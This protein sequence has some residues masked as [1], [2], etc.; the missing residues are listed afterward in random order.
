MDRTPP[1][2][3]PPGPRELWVDVMALAGGDG[4]AQHPAKDLSAVLAPNQ[5]VHLKSGLYR[6]PFTLPKDVQLI[7]EGQAVLYVE[8][9]EGAVVSMPEGGALTRLSVQGGRTGVVG[10]KTV[11][12]EQVH[13]SGHRFAAL[14]MG[15]GVLSANNVEVEASVPDSAGFV[16]DATP[17]TPAPEE[18]GTEPPG[19]RR[20][21]DGVKAALS[22]TLRG[23]DFRGGLKHA[24][25][26]RGA[27]LELSD[28]ELDGVATPIRVR[29]S[30]AVLRSVSLKAG[31][32]PAVFAAD[33]KVSVNGLEVLGHEYAFQARASELAVEGVH[34]VGSEHASVAA[35]QCTGSLKKLRLERPGN[36]AAIQVLSSKL[37]IGEV[38]IRDAD[39]AGIMVRQGEVA[40]DG[41]KV[42]G[43]RA[44]ANAAGT[45]DTG[46]DALMLRGCTGTVKRVEIED[47]E[48]VG[49][50]FSAAAAMQV[51]GLSCR[52]CGLGAMLVELASRIQASRV[53]VDGAHGPAVSVI[54][55]GQ[56]ELA[57]LSSHGAEVPVWAECGNGA[58]AK[59]SG[60]EGQAQPSSPCVLVKK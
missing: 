58:I 20:A 48:G 37:T 19:P 40:I 2:V 45:R 60:V 17:E 39:A 13:F 27:S 55:H 44:E 8:G 28:S 50:W 54:D 30:V 5:R 43:V 21:L 31:R 49:A 59:V 53:T 25:D 26:V 6:G 52:R 29:D 18:N 4:S 12:L 47:A 14:A 22:V 36:F 32:G 56:L 23:A 38:E 1:P 9:A 3:P 11:A 33:S 24:L 57:G 34:A 16:L 46:G 51:D 35:V 10:A 42:H 7:G 15:S 41:V